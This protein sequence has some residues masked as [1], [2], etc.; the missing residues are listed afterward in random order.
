MLALWQPTQKILELRTLT[1]MAEL[2]TLSQP[3]ACIVVDMPLVLERVAVVGGRRCDSQARALLPTGRKSSIF[4]A[5]TLAALEAW[6]LGGGYREVLA[7]QRQTGAE[8]PGLSLQAFNLL[9]HIDDLRRY[10][11]VSRA[12]TC[13]EGHPELA[14]ERQHRPTDGPL[15]S[16]HKAHGR[17]QRQKILTALGM[18]WSKAWSGRRRDVNSPLQANLGDAI[19]ACM[20][21]HVSH[22][23]QLGLASRCPIEARLNDGSPAIF[24]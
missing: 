13:L 1:T 24:F 3:P 5:P 10:V 14:F 7:A 17:E 11:A 19:D 6:R 4:S 8:T 16:K 2:E 18:P 12:G 20:M 15:V 23:H 9:K 21:A 22:Q